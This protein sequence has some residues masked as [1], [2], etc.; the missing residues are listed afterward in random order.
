MAASTTGQ[1]VEWLKQ[2]AT[3]F[4][5]TDPA[6]LTMMRS[7]Q[8]VL[9]PYDPRLLHQATDR[10]LACEYP[11]FIRD[12]L[13]A[14]L[15]LLCDLTAAE[16]ERVTG[17]ASQGDRGSCGLCGGTGRVTVPH[18]RAVHGGEWVPLKVA[19]GGAAYY[20]CAVC[21]TCPLGRWY[22]EHSEGRSGGG[23][24]AAPMALRDYERTNPLWREQLAEREQLLAAELAATAALQGRTPQERATAVALDRILRRLTEGMMG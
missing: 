21:C 22:E 2:H 10:L 9:G 19:R 8:T 6:E 4:G 11:S 23:E 12:H 16:V 1:Y 18:P 15:A 17:F 5:V 3:A 14:L 20:T 7:W 13:R 24:P